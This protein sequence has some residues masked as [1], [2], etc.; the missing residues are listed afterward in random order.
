M[1]ATDRQRDGPER[2]G[3]LDV[4]DRPLDLASAPADPSARRGSGPRRAALLL[5]RNVALTLRVALLGLVLTGAAAGGR[6]VDVLPWVVALATLAALARR[7]DPARHPLA[8]PLLESG[9]CCAGIVETSGAAS[10]L[11]AYLL[12]P[13]VAVGLASGVRAVAVVAGLDIA[14]LLA[15]PALLDPR[16]AAGPDLA[17]TAL[18]WVGLGLAVGLLGAWA[19]VLSSARPD[20]A[21]SRESRYAEAHQLLDRLRAVTRRLPGSLD[22]KSS[23]QQVLDRCQEVAPGTDRAAVLLVSDE[24]EQLVPLAVRG[25]RRVPWRSPL[26]E[27]G[28]LGLAHRERRAVLDVRGPDTE[29]RLPAARGPAGSGRRRGSALLALPLLLGERSLGLVV[30]E[31]RDLTAFDGRLPEL[32]RV[33]AEEALH[34]DSGLLFEEVRTW[35]SLQERAR[36]ARDMHDGVAQ[37]LAY[38]GFELDSLRHRLTREAP[39]L[40]E[41]VTRLR[42]QLTEMV[43]DLRL[44]ITDLRSGHGQERGLGAALTSYA[45]SVATARGLA[46]HLSLTESAFRLPGEAEV[47]LF[48][49]AQEAVTAARR[50]QSARNLW[51]SLTVDPPSA[52]LRIEHDGDVDP[53]RPGRDLDLQLVGEHVDRLGGDLTLAPRPGGGLRLDVVLEGERI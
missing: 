53:E 41:D 25:A 13:F 16:L 39:A 47:Q 38:V 1:G 31:S 9:V 20:S 6:L 22:P 10:P 7:V 2:D 11:A 48:K 12:A 23:A 3:G 29:D 30:L 4:V 33:L 49:V 19:G 46:V 27:P 26:T 36:L 15:A 45:R 32:A 37:D 34:L 17:A 24:P 35:A 18:Q 51:I 5:P 40:V 42:K 28:P 8:V 50:D 43:S 21:E 52:L 44:S 14:V